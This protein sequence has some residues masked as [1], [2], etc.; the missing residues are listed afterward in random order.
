MKC[1]QNILSILVDSRQITTH[2]D[3]CV[4]HCHFLLFLFRERSL[5]EV[6]VLHESPGYDRQHTL[7]KLHDKKQLDFFV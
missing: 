1:L 7:T 2:Q 3:S 4:K 6:N 5:V